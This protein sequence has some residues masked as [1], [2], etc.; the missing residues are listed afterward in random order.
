MGLFSLCCTLHT[1]GKN[2]RLSFVVDRTIPDSL[3]DLLE[4]SLSGSSPV[5][6]LSSV[7]LLYGV[8]RVVTLA[9]RKERGV[10]MVELTKQTKKMAD[11]VT[12]L[13]R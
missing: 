4:M 1:I 8:W 5:F 6:C 3:F 13:A 9:R 7:W 12:D 10:C 2:W 11:C